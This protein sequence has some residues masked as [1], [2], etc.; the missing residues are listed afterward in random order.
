MGKKKDKKKMV[1]Q[2][3]N[4]RKLDKQMK[5]NL[6]KKMGKGDQFKLT[7]QYMEYVKAFN[8]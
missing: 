4:Q 8:I 5:I 1:E 2:A 6:R 7:K 3:R